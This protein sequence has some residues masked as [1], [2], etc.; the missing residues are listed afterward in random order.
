MKIYRAEHRQELRGP[1][2]GRHSVKE[3]EWA[4]NDDVHP[5]IGE[6][7]LNNPAIGQWAHN[8]ADYIHGMPSK[9]S[10]LNWF[11]GYLSILYDNDFVLKTFEVPEP[12]FATGI[13]AIFDPQYA[14][15]I[16]TEEFTSFMNKGN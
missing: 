12:H 9:E 1:Y 2:T 4:H 7:A 10:L 14:T 8:H 6:E 13:Q 15:L 3:I 16:E 11:E 5:T